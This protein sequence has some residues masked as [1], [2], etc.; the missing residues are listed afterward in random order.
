MLAGM[1][2]ASVSTRKVS[3]MNCIAGISAKAYSRDKLKGVDL[4]YE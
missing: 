3:K 2:V 1:A 4:D